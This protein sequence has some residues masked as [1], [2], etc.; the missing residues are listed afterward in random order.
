MVLNKEEYIKRFSLEAWEKKLQ[1]SREG[2]REHPEKGRKCLRLW[3][4]DNPQKAKE[5]NYNLCHKDGKYYEV[6]YNHVKTGIPY[7]KK[8]IRNK[9]SKWWRAYKRIIA[10]DSQV[11]HEWIANTSEY[12]GIALVE[13]NQHLH[14]FIDVIQILEGEITLL[15]EEEIRE[16]NK[17]V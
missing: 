11:H 12:R 1:R 2:K 16:S 7:E 4:L 13:T 15:T 3:R 10:P 17:H 8:I 14:G 9:H 6:A 5:I